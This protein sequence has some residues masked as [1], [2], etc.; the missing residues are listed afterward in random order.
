LG[1]ADAAR[2]QVRGQGR[3]REVRAPRISSGRKE[4]YDV[5]R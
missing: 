5:H 4:Q 1:D 3:E 2:A